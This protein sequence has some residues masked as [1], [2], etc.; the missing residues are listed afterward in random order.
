MVVGVNWM[1][2]RACPILRTLKHIDDREMAITDIRIVLA[3]GL[4]CEEIRPTGVS[5]KEAARYAGLSPAELVV[6]IPHLVDARYLHE[7][8]P[9]FGNGT[10]Y[11]LGS[12]G[13]TYMRGVKAVWHAQ[14]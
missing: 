2:D 5:V 3:V 7:H 14:G 12:V 4:A 13:G 9:T 11:R 10:F 8:V 6:R 1:V